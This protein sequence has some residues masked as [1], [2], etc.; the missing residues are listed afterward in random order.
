MSILDNVEEERPG[1]EFL[2]CLRGLLFAFEA[3]EQA[4]VGPEGAGGVQA[5]DALFVAELL[6]RVC[7]GDEDDVGA[8]VVD[9]GSG[10]ADAGEVDVRGD[11]F[12]SGEMT[13]AFG[14]DLV[15]DVEAGDVGSDVL[16]DCQGNRVGPYG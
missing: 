15:F 11:D 1:C 10:G 7:A 16:L 3:F 5:C 4:Y 6:Q 2:D 8:C 12:L 9:C 13:A 14:E